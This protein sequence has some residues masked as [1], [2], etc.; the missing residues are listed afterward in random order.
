MNGTF[1]FEIGGI[2][3]ERPKGINGWAMIGLHGGE[4]DGENMEKSGT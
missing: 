1:V 2:G 3:K 4:K